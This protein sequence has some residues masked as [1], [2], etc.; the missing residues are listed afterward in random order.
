MLS[1]QQFFATISLL[2]SHTLYPISLYLKYRV[3]W[4]FIGLSLF[5]NISTWFWLLWNIRPQEEL[6]FLHYTILF[7]ID[8]L[9]EWWKILVIPIAGLIIII[10]NFSL[11]WLL[12]DKDKFVSLIVNGMSVVCNTF[13]LIAAALLVF[14]NV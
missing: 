2:M 13:L 10:I 4:F 7:G 8:Y 1:I 5:L 12:F 11:G 9:G 3:S 14:L 6:L